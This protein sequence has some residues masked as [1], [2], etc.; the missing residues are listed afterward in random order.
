MNADKRKS[1]DEV[2][3][4]LAALGR[5][6]KKYGVDEVYSWCRFVL[7][8]KPGNFSAEQK[9]A[10]AYFMQTRHKFFDGLADVHDLD[11]GEPDFYKIPQEFKPKV[12]YRLSKS[13]MQ[14]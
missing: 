9:I 3:K 12:T 10:A 2:L 8:A 11:I 13:Y 5:R 6:A 1:F 14:K 7:G 4:A